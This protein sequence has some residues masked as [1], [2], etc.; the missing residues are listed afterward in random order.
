MTAQK[1]RSQFAQGLYDLMIS[2]GIYP[3]EEWCAH[4][5]PWEEYK[6]EHSTLHTFGPEAHGAPKTMALIQSWFD[7]AGLPTGEHQNTILYVCKGGNV[8]A[9]MARLGTLGEKD[10]EWDMYVERFKKGREAQEKAIEHFYQILDRYIWDVSPL[11]R[12]WPHEK[13]LLVP[14][15]KMNMHAHMFENLLSRFYGVPARHLKSVIWEAIKIVCEAEK[16]NWYEKT[17]EK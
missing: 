6:K 15:P 13:I 4:I 8:S 17:P 7:D 12:E 14:H 1:E 9:F 16:N 10:P 11:G 5:N 3:I 2:P